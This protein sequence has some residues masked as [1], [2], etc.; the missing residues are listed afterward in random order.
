AIGGDV[1]LFAE[2][3][4]LTRYYDLVF[5]EKKPTHAPTAPP[6]GVIKAPGPS[7][8]LAETAAVR[9]PFDHFNFATKINR[10]FLRDVSIRDLDTGIR[11]DGGRV[12]L[13]PCRLVLNDA[14]V[15]ARAEVNLG[16]SD[17]QY[18][19]ALNTGAI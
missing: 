13:N 8:P 6:N 14:A 19:L 17:W 10:F 3:L 9:L 4:D 18:E 11:I 1:Q 7:P 15:D 5:P 2:S 16:V 12:S